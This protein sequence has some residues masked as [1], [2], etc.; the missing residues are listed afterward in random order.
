VLSF[1]I[2]RLWSGGR[3]AITVSEK[4]TYTL[5]LDH[6]NNQQGKEE[7]MATKKTNELKLYQ[8][9]H[10]LNKIRLLVEPAIEKEELKL[11]STVQKM[12]DKGTKAFAKSIGADKVIDRLEKAEEELRLASRSAHVFFNREAKK[13][14]TLS[15]GKRSDFDRDNRDQIKSSDCQD[16]LEDW[17]EIQA[18]QSAKTTE[19]G[20]Y[21]SY[22][23]A[24]KHKANDEVKEANV[25]DELKGTLDNLFAFVGITWSRKLPPR[26]KQIASR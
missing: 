16:Q 12:L 23:E 25:S 5:S 10:F 7:T 13:S 3:L 18:K 15:K 2:K 17:A 20:K 22:L 6:H 24:L 8:R 21:L 11:K 4:C 14:I 1:F 19:Q 26:P 9:E